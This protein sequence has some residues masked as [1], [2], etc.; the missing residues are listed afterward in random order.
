MGGLYFFF[1]TRYSRDRKQLG[2]AEWFYVCSAKLWVIILCCFVSLSTH[3]C[4]NSLHF[5][6]HLK[7]IIS[8]PHTVHHPKFLVPK[9]YGNFAN[10][11]MQH[12]FLQRIMALLSL[13]ISFRWQLQVHRYKPRPLNSVWGNCGL[14][15]WY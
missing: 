3:I 14:C 9:Q 15:L 6:L 7:V 10:K 11:F 8:Q 4:T 1:R 13:G 12:S 5:S 2:H